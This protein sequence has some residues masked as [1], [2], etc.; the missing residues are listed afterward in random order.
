MRAQGPYRE[1]SENPDIVHWTGFVLDITESKKNAQK[2]EELS[3]RLSYLGLNLPG[4]LYEMLL[5]PNG[6]MAFTYISPAVERIANKKADE[7][8][9]SS[10]FFEEYIYPEDYQVVIDNFKESLSSRNS[11]VLDFRTTHSTEGNEVWN[12]VHQSTVFDQGGVRLLGFWTNITEEKKKER[13]LEN[14]R[15]QIYHSSK[16]ASLGEML[17]SLA[18]E[19]NNPMTIIQGYSTQLGKRLDS[20]EDIDREVLRKRIETIEKTSKRVTGIIKGLRSLSSGAI[21][22]NFQ[23]HSVNQI[24]EDVKVLCEEGMKN[25][26]IDF[27]I[28]SLVEDI[29][30]RCSNVQICQVLINFLSNARDALEGIEKAYVK[31]QVSKISGIEKDCRQDYVELRVIDNGVG[32]S[33]E[34]EKIFE[35]FFTTKP[36][37]KGTGLG[38]SVSKSIV[39]NHNGEIFAERTANETHLVMCLPL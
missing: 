34:D 17:G 20:Q 28:E 31:L 37:N 6:E 13:M 8:M 38:L 36:V 14:Q 35:P 1:D 16:M 5:K 21:D 25:H 23:A 32:F 11:M 39:D 26:S 3:R 12:R 33:I 22:N 30:L 7:I 9:K 18:H 24:I 15:A 19:I 10:N 2:N 29:K 27:Q 4:A